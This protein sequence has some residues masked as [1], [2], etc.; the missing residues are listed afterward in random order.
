M[1]QR[2]IESVERSGNEQIGSL[3]TLSVIVPFRKGERCV[4]DCLESVLNT[5]YPF[6]KLD[7]VVVDDGHDDETVGMLRRRLPVVRIVRN[8]NSAGSDKAKQMGVQAATGEVLA[9]TDADCTVEPQW[10]QAI[11]ENLRNGADVVTGPVRH[12]TTFLRE[13]IGIAD[14]QD[15]QGLKHR[16]ASSFLGGNVGARREV[17]ES[18][19]YRH[20]G[21]TSWGSD[22]LTSWR[23]YRMGLKIVYDPA[24]VIHHRPV[25]SLRGICERRMRY[26]RKAL[27]LRKRDG[28]LPGGMIARLGPLAAPAYLCYRS[29]KDML[30]LAEMTRDRVV[31]PWHIPALIPALLLFR[32]M[33]A[34]G[35]VSS[36]LSR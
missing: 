2:T 26:G 29:A 36:Q 6:E 27:D 10:A 16:S 20:G 14:F 18:V 31:N 35:V 25:V 24:M 3:P 32:L 22:R 7:L 19:T 1:N 8:D 13:L 17:W 4:M 11:A 23:M 5:D 33:D 12:G 28:S 9:I 30:R 15:F 34:A 21:D